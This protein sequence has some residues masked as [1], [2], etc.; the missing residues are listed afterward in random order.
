MP[1]H[2]FQ[3][4]APNGLCLV[5]G[6]CFPGPRILCLAHH[7]HLNICR[8]N[9][10]SRK[11]GRRGGAEVLKTWNC[12]IFELQRTLKVIL[13]NHLHF[14]DKESN[15]RLSHEERKQLPQFLYSGSGLSPHHEVQGPRGSILQ[16]PTCHLLCHR[17]WRAELPTKSLQNAPNPGPLPVNVQI[18][19]FQETTYFNSQ[20]MWSLKRGEGLAMCNIL[21]KGKCKKESRTIQKRILYSLKTNRNVPEKM[22]MAPPQKPWM[23]S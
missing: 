2:C 13:S 17:E 1:E 22:L 10:E 20:V 6:F 8:T 9:D 18:D 4:P 12:T 14:V 7:C 11:A 21:R 3:A 15:L 5:P 16:E 23:K 19:F